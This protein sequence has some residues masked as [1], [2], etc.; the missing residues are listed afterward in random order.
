MRDNSLGALRNA[1]PDAKG[2]AGKNINSEDDVYWIVAN[3]SYR[4]FTPRTINGLKK[5][6]VDDALRSLAD[7][8]FKY[9]RSEKQTD[10]DK[11][12]NET[13][14]AF[15]TEFKAQS[16]Q[17]IMYGK[18][19]KI[20]N[21]TMK[22]L[23]CM[24]G[25]EEYIER[26]KDC[27]MPLDT[28]TLAWFC[29]T[30]VSWY[31]KKEEAK[32]TRI[33]ITKIKNTS[34]SNLECGSNGVQY[35]YLWMQKLIREYLENKDNVNYRNEKGDSLTPLEAEFYIWPEQKFIQACKGLIDQDVYR[36]EYPACPDEGLTKTCDKIIDIIQ[37]FRE[38]VK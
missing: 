9:V 15:Q 19:Q 22:Y 10:Y 7:R 33:S 25:S 20:V 12:H 4:D 35:S 26:F 24:Q 32:T 16:G 21:M 31:K 38:K 13:C 6:M 37:A 5:E 34:W 36:D 23:L 18:A 14:L 27:H 3:L 30:V 8:V 29:D 2:I 28:Y 17:G 1:F 11:W